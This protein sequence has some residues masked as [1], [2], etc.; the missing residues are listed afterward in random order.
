MIGA[1]G[2][3]WFGMFPNFKSDYC[4]VVGSTF[5]KAKVVP[6]AGPFAYDSLGGPRKS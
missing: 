2:F 5:R 3:F 4:T 1:F 6:L